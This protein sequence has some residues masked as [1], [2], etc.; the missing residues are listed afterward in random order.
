M[1]WLKRF[2]R[3]V[4]P[5]L[6]CLSTV[7]HS[8]LTLLRKACRR[9][10]KGFISGRKPESASPTFCS[11][12]TIRPANLLLASHVRLGNC[13]CITTANLPRAEATYLRTRNLYFHS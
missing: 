11:V 10:L 2:S 8:R 9:Y 1:I 3:L 6:C 5:Q 12:I 7:D 4:S 13:R